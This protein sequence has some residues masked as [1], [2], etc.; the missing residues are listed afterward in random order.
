[1]KRKNNYKPYFCDC[2]CLEIC[3]RGHRFISGHNSRVENPFKGKHSE[4]TKMKMRKKHNI[5][6]ESHEIMSLAKIGKLPPNKNVPHTKEA[7]LKMRLSKLGKTQSKEHVKKRL[8]AR[9]KTCEARGYYHTPAEK[10]KIK[11]SNKTTWK[12]TL[13]EVKSIRIK[14]VL[15][16]NGK[17]PNNQ[18]KQMDLIIQ[19]ARPLDFKFTGN[20]EVV[21]GGKNPDWF[22]VNGKK[23][24]IEFFGDYWHS[25][26]RT[27][28]AKEQEEEFFK[29]HYAKYGYGCLVIWSFELKNP[30]EILEK[31]KN[32]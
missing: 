23:Q 10:A 32:F 26:K 6:P 4:N 16:S 20:G 8:E 12:N 31:I 2:G 24:V 27:G 13:D 18:E 11:S 15:S 3:S 5:S 19:K 25:E 1:M 22:N 30:D 17:H 21:I 9:I 28:R 29:F 14:K 7:K